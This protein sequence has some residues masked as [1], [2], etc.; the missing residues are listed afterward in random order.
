MLDRYSTAELQCPQPKVPSCKKK[1]NPHQTPS[2]EHLISNCQTSQNRATS[3]VSTPCPT[4]CTRI[5]HPTHTLPWS[6]PFIMADEQ[7]NSTLRKAPMG[8]AE[9]QHANHLLTIGHP[10]ASLSSW[11]T[12]AFFLG[13]SGLRGQPEVRRGRTACS[14]ENQTGH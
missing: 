8:V 6:K 1:V 10:G 5:P 2:Q 7:Y 4:P 14:R 9:M 12:C 11:T 13:D 3:S